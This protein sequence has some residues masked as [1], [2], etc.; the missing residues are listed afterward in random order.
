MCKMV[1]YP[2]RINMP[3][4]KRE[5]LQ[6]CVTAFQRQEGKDRPVLGEDSAGGRAG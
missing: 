5:G 3:R 4:R 1:E 2:N 6:A